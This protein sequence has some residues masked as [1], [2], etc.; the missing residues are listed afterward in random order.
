M[1]PKANLLAKTTYVDSPL[2]LETFGATRPN[3]ARAV[4]EMLESNERLALAISSLFE[5]L[6][7]LDGFLDDCFVA[8]SWLSPAPG[9]QHLFE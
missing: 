8:C 5:V 6:A 3:A 2:V 4:Q 9:A 7:A 1:L